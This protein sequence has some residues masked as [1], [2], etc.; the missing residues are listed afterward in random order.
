MMRVFFVLLTSSPVLNQELAWRVM[1]CFSNAS[2]MNAVSKVDF[3]K[4]HCPLQT[5]LGDLYDQLILAEKSDEWSELKGEVDEVGDVF[6]RVLLVC[7]ALLALLSSNPEARGLSAKDA[8]PLLTYKGEGPLENSLRQ[9]LMENKTWQKLIDLTNRVAGT[10]KL[11]YPKLVSI[12]LSLEECELDPAKLFPVLC[13]GLGQLEELRQN[14]KP[15]ATNALE[16]LMGRAA[17][18][19]VKYLT[20]CK[21]IS[22]LDT[23]LFPGFSQN[24]LLLEREAGITDAMVPLQWLARKEV[25][26]DQS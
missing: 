6:G 4:D 17:T 11:W 16:N 9:I 20:S 5:A 21:E 14:L 23:S 18:T 19:V 2:F 10:A 12:G 26:G 15:N 22:E 8:V 13:D 24:L 1:N 25:Q 7:S 3:G